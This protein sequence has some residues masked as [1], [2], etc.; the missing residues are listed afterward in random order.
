MYPGT[1]SRY[2][3]AVLFLVLALGWGGSYPAMK[4]GLDHGLPAVFY[5][6]LR[7]D[8]AAIILLAY[9]AVSIDDWLVRTR[10]DAKYVLVSAG[11]VVVVNNAF[12]LYGQQYTSSGIA[13]MVY[14]LNP[15]LSAGFARM[16]LSR[17]EFSMAERLGLLLGFIGIVVIARPD[18]G[19]IG[20]QT[21]GIAVLLV[22][23][24]AVAL[25]SVLTRRTEPTVSTLAGSA[26]AMLI[27]AVTLHASAAALGENPT[28]QPTPAL[29]GAVVFLGVVGTAVAYGSY[30]TLLDT[31]G[32]VRT[33]LVSYLVPIVASVTSW[34]V[35]GSS[36]TG[37]TVV[38]F[39][40][41]FAGFVCLNWTAFTDEVS[42]L[43][44]RVSEN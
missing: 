9:A 8:F 37:V 23:A 35:L 28:I 30:F 25:G 24:S 41:I 31:I 19:N 17:R 10:E 42:R 13:S 36:M 4:Y 33:N 32:P 1:V 18:P 14:S 39:A 12:L 3:R 43:S 27:G 5:A 7:F 20:T 26:W 40:I 22:A 16:L 15:I 21:Y 38:G 34:L 6:G 11:F 44:S 29:I 2:H